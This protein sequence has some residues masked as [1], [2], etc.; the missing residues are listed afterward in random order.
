[1][2]RPGMKIILL[3]VVGLAGCASQGP[4]RHEQSATLRPGAL[5][6]GGLAL[7]TP[8]TVTGQEQD[9][10]AVALIFADT[11]TR[12]RPKVRLVTLAETLSAVNRADLGDAYRRMFEDYRDTGLFSPEALQ[13]IAAAT[14]VRYIGQ[15]NLQRFQQFSKSRFSVP[16]VNIRF[17]ETQIGHVRLFF[18]IWDASTGSIAWEGVEEH[19]ITSERVVEAPILQRTLI[20]AAA[21]DLFHRLP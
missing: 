3:L 6:A 11:F 17:L 19:S 15:L 21:E 16:L 8:S 5:E 12:E 18:Q 9:K 10:Q 1:M 20:H 14:G 2:S 13:R 4:A 7:I